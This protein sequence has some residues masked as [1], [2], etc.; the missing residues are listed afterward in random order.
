MVQKRNEELKNMT[1]AELIK[2]M[3]KRQAEMLEGR[4]KGAGAGERNVHAGRNMRRDI[5]RIK[6]EMRRRELAEV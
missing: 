5:A 2:Q 6:T 1:D 3:Q 4:F